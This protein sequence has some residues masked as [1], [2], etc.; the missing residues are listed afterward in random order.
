MTTPT[1]AECQQLLTLE[2]HAEQRGIAFLRGVTFKESLILNS[3]EPS[4]EVQTEKGE[5]ITIRGS[6]IYDKG[7][8]HKFLKSTNQEEAIYQLTHV[9]ETLA[10]QYKAWLLSAHTE[11]YR[12]IS[13]EAHF[14]WLEKVVALAVARRIMEN[15]YNA[16]IAQGLETFADPRTAIEIGNLLMLNSHL[17]DTAR[18]VHHIVKDPAHAQQIIAQVSE[19][20]YR[21]IQARSFP[22]RE[23][24]PP[25]PPGTPS[26][27]ALLD[28]IAEKDDE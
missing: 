20:H 10:R 26:P 15:K 27:F 16:Y 13:S 3:L 24:L 9:G 8:W 22:L 28:Q 1:I 14:A 12:F 25:L 11:R 2:K 6:D 18:M 21:Q 5:T 7:T 4:I 23:P 19:E 17:K